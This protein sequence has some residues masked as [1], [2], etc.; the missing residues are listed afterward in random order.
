M[1]KALTQLIRYQNEIPHLFNTNQ[2]LVGLNLF[3]SKYGSISAEPE[4]FHEWK[5]KNGEKF[6]N[7]AEHP[8]IKEMIE[9]GMIKKKTCL[10]S[11]LLRKS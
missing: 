1:S 4:Q 11:P 10:I 2:L 7:M 6:P 3:G 5:D 9:L 8:S